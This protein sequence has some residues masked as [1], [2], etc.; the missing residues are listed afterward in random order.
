MAGLRAPCNLLRSK[1]YLFR[2]PENRV[3]GVGT[4]TAASADIAFRK[5][6]PFLRNAFALE[7]ETLAVMRDPLSH[8][9]NWFRYRRAEAAHLDMEGVD[10]DAFVG[11]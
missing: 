11:P 2:G 8:L 1:P 3:Q 7:P 6:R 5:E 4:R 9:R 10:L